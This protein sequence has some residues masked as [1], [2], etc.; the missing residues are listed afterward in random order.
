MSNFICKWLWIKASAKCKFQSGFRSHHSV[1]T[2]LVKISNDLLP[3][4]DSGLQ[5]ILILFDLNAAF[6]TISH[7]ILM[8]RLESIGIMGMA[9]TWFRSY[10]TGRTQFVQLKQF[11]SKPSYVTTGVPR[12]SVLG[13]L[14]FIYLLPLGNICKKF[15]IH[16]Y[17]DDTQLYMSSKPTFTFSLS[18]LS[19]CVAE[20]KDWFTS[21]LF[22]LNSSKTEI[23]LVGSK[24]TLAKSKCSS[25]NVNFPVSV[26]KQV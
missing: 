14:L 5:S 8:D 20:I 17:A 3:A 25:V 12:G 11:T 24:T 4:A 23:L 1:E 19:D 2:A 15:G 16:C 10:L 18:I 13:P 7:S 26:S 22:N 9:L 6:D 21:N